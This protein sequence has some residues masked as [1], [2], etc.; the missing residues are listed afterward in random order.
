MA[1]VLAT[2]IASISANITNNSV[3]FPIADLCTVEVSVND[4]SD[5]GN[6]IH[7][8]IKH[9]DRED[10]EIL[11]QVRCKPGALIKEIKAA[12]EQ[13]PYDQLP[14]E[15]AIQLYAQEKYMYLDLE[16]EEVVLTSLKALL[17]GKDNDGKT[18]LDLLKENS[19]RVDRTKDVE[20][21][22]QEADA[23]PE[24]DK[25]AL[26]EKRMREHQAGRA[27]LMIML[28]K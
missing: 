15:L 4:T 21:Y 7:K 26:R 25:K 22:I 10:F 20:L 24:E 5:N 27:L 13:Y 11:W 6:I 23:V 2:S 19:D 3:S 12:M 8:I 1:L 14:Q 28:S 16:T 9:Y 18:A 17:S